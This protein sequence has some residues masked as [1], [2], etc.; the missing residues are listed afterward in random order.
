MAS[1]MEKLFADVKSFTEGSVVKGKVLEVRSNE[2]LVDIGFKSEGLV[3]LEEFMHPEAVKVGDEIEVLLERL[4][5]DNGMVVLSHER[6]QQ[7]KNWDRIV[8]LC[9]EGGT[10]EGKVKAKVKGG[11]MVNAGVDAFLPASQI[12]VLPPRNLDDFIGKTFMFKIVK[13]NTDRRNIVVSRRELIEQE[14]DDKR[15]NQIDAMKVGELRTGAVKNITDFGAF[16][17]LNGLDGL[18]HVTDMSWGRIAHPSELVKVGDQIEVMILEIDRDKG[19]VSLGLKQKN[20]NPWD[21]IA[22]KFPVGSR[23]RGKVVSVMPYGAFIQLEPGVEGMVHVSELSWTKR[24]ARASD[25]LKAGD[26][27]EAVVLD[28][29]RDEQKIALGLRQLEANPWTQVQKKYPVG[30]KITGQV[31]NL[32]NFGAFVEV[33]EG[34]DGMVHVSD[35]SWTRKVT[36]PAEVLKKG[37]TVDAV[38]L[39][40]D[41][42][43]QRMALGLKQLENDPWRDVEKKYRI[44]DVVK[45]KVVKLTTFGAFIELGDKIEGLVHIS[46]ITEERVEKIKSVLKVGDEVTARV[47]KVDTNERRIGLSI[48]AAAYSADQLEAEKAQYEA[49]LKPGE[50]IVDLEHAFEQ[51]EDEKNQ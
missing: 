44:G 8:T 28:I 42:A 4:E 17:D 45:G 23:V 18:L 49:N 12:D 30:T 13:I 36:N 3:P 34:V 7:Q 38:V 19:R 27:V 47:L 16:V 51:A 39:E 31:R 40:V 15:K 32:T 5:D 43:N 46:Q 50:A 37:Q 9:N 14:R 6:A 41:G 2:V 20:R 29:K 10:I 1:S 26:D 25:M 24:V 35:I 11:L 33:E 21:D 22:L 48:K